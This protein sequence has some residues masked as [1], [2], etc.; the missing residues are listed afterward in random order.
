[1]SEY[2]EKKAAHSPGPRCQTKLVP[3][4][5][6]PHAVEEMVP[7]QPRS[8]HVAEMV[9]QGGHHGADPEQHE[10]EAPATS[11]CLT[12]AAVLYNAKKLS[13]LPHDPPLYI[14]S[15]GTPEGILHQKVQVAAGWSIPLS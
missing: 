5:S 14:A 4:V 2:S 6:I 8:T 13:K 10:T 9:Q 1:M 15:L 7:A 11:H 3:A 12:I